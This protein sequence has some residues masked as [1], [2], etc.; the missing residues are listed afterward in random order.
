MGGLKKWESMRIQNK[1]GIRSPQPKN[2]FLPD[3][4]PE[5]DADTNAGDVF[6]DECKE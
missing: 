4:Q 6:R 3:G 5:Y 1:D 2:S